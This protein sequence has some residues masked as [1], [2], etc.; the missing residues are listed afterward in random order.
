M[1]II[2]VCQ[3]HIYIHFFKGTVNEISS[4]H[5]LK[6]D[7]HAKFTLKPFLIN[8]VEDIVIFYLKCV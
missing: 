6:K 3:D 4:F 1:D 8:N 5:P 2:H 7:W